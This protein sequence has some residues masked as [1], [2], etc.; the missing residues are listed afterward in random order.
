MWGRKRPSPPHCSRGSGGSK[1]EH[2]C[3]SAGEWIRQPAPTRAMEHP[4]WGERQSHGNTS[5]MGKTKT[6]MCG[7]KGQAKKERGP[8]DSISVEFWKRQQIHLES[9]SRWRAAQ[10]G[11]RVA[12]THHGGLPGVGEVPASTV[13]VGRGCRRCQDSSD[14]HLA[15]VRFIVRELYLSEEQNKKT[16]VTLRA[17]KKISTS[18]V[19]ENS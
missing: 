4:E 11:G 16:A 19:S 8:C 7:D 13:G 2:M 3:P 6:V 9:E 15:W 5:H 10:A 17:K 14:C 1:S 18:L 12:E